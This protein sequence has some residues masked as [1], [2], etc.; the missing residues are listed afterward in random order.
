[1]EIQR[2][3]GITINHMARVTSPCMCRMYSR[4][5]VRDNARANLHKEE[6]TASSIEY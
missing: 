3:A 6:S 5:W 1:M 4:C 2:V